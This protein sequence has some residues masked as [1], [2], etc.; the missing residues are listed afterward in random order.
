MS[1]PTI[2]RIPRSDEQGAFVLVHASQTRSKPLD[3]KLVGTDGLAPY[4]TFLRHSQASSLMVKNSPVSEEEWLEIL[5]GIL[6]QEPTEGMEAVASVE[7]ESSIVIT[8]RKQVRGVTQRLGTLELKHAPDEEIELFDWCG[9][10]ADAITQ[11]KKALASAA[12]KTAELEKAGAELHRQL[13]ELIQAKNADE[14]AMLERFRDLLNEKKVKIREQLRLLADAT[15]VPNVLAQ[16]QQSNSMKSESGKGHLAQRSRPTKRKVPAHEEAAEE[17][18]ESEG[19]DKMDVDS[20]TR[21][22]APEASDDQRETTDAETEAETETASEGMDEDE[23]E[24][25]KRAPQPQRATSSKQSA[26]VRQ[27]Q[28][29]KPSPQKENTPPPRRDLPFMKKK[30]EKRKATPPPAGSETESDD[31]L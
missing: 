27:S 4:M 7:S 26:S 5:S 11:A 31:E 16:S 20:T 30:A 22:S 17:D 21:T 3:L 2:L 8:F 15:V 1:T 24:D 14:A 25:D 12:A 9:I 6:H 29:S 13:G 23:D 19:F 10:A 28:E 18:D